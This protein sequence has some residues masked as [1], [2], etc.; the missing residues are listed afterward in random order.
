LKYRELI[1]AQ[2]PHVKLKR[3]T[4]CLVNIDGCEANVSNLE[5]ALRLTSST[6]TRQQTHLEPR[7]HALAAVLTVF[8][9][10]AP[11]PN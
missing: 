7:R 6:S 11:L 5:L 10:S 8:K 1:M 3:S 2:H 4:P 9:P